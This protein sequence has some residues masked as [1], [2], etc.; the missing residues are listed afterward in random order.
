MKILGPHGLRVGM[1]LL[2][3][4]VRTAVRRTLPA[5]AKYFMRAL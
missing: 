1:G 5:M 4:T 2:S 3:P